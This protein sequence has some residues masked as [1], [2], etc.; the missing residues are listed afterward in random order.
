MQEQCK[1]KNST[2]V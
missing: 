1:I 2:Q